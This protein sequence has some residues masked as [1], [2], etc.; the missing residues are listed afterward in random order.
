MIKKLNVYGDTL[1]PCDDLFSKTKQCAYSVYRT[2]SCLAVNVEKGIWFQE[3]KNT[4]ENMLVIIL[5]KKINNVS[6]SNNSS[7]FI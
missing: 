5:E 6:L 4:E 7:N 2:K 1:K 3:K